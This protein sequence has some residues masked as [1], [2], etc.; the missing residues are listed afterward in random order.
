MDY[1]TNRYLI[2]IGCHKAIHHVP[3][4]SREGGDINFS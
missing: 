3:V 2:N 4:V 1:R